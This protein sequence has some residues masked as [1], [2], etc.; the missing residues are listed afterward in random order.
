[1]K[2]KIVEIKYSSLTPTIYDGGRIPNLFIP[3]GETNPFYG[4]E[5]PEEFTWKLNSEPIERVVTLENGIEL[6][7]I[8]DPPFKIEDNDN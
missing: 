8:F 4:I 7:V 5:N 1:M 2:E 3:E 6:K